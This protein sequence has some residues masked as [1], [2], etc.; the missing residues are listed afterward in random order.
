MF[1]WMI[2]LG[3]LC[4]AVASVG[5][6]FV[7]LGLVWHRQRPR[8]LPAAWVVRCRRCRELASRERP[9]LARPDRPRKALRSTE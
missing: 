1:E 7:V 3:A 6:F 2:V 5:A 4:G 9:R 8:V